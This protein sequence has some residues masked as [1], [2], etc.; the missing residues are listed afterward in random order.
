MAWAI[1][2][3]ELDAKLDVVNGV[4]L[5]VLHG[6]DVVDKS[7]GELSGQFERLGVIIGR[8]EEPGLA[9]GVPVGGVSGGL[10]AEIGRRGRSIGA[11]AGVQNGQPHFLV[12]EGGLRDE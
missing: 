5:D 10:P 3:G 12:G 8:V 7:I 2:P 4:G 6:I 9:V 1:E 11:K